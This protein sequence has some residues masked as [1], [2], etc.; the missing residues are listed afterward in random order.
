MFTTVET[1]LVLVLFRPRKSR[2]TEEHEE[3]EAVQNQDVCNMSNFGLR[4]KQHLLFG[5]AQEE[6]ATGIQQERRQELEAV[7]ILSIFRD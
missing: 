6:E 3:G 5:G 2:L 7:G 4:Q 1:L